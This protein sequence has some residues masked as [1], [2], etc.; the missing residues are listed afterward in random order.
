MNEQTESSEQE[1][2]NAAEFEMWR[3]AMIKEFKA[4]Q[5]RLSAMRKE[6][7]KKMS[8]NEVPLDLYNRL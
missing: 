1:Q 4:T 3:D 7:L 2:S 6:S 8:D 5:D